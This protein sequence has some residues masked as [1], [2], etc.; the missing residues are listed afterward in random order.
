MSILVTRRSLYLALLNLLPGGFLFS[1]VKIAIYQG[2]IL[3]LYELF[4]EAFYT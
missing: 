3:I 4:S 2:F 1:A